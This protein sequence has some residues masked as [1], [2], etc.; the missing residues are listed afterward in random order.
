MQC[1]EK[2]GHLMAITALN[3][4]RN[5]ARVLT[6]HLSAQCERIEIA[7]LQRRKNLVGWPQGHKRLV[8][9]RHDQDLQSA[10]ALCYAG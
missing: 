5:T 2:G 3:A 9:I 8:V 10:P 4:P 6:I 1:E 7:K